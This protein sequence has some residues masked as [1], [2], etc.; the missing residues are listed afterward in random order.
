MDIKEV[1]RQNKVAQLCTKA[2]VNIG[3]LTSCIFDYCAF[4]GDYA[5]VDNAVIES[6]HMNN[7]P[8]RLRRL[9]SSKAAACAQKMRGIWHGV[10][11]RIRAFSKRGMPATSTGGAQTKLPEQHFSSKQLLCHGRSN[12][13]LVCTD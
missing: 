1:C 2:K 6:E 9:V 4:G 3:F 12:Q 8:A 5:A 7:P 11:S 10:N 13:A